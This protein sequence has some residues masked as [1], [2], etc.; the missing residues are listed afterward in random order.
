MVVVETTVVQVQLKQFR[1]EQPT[2]CK[3]RV[4]VKIEVHFCKHFFYLK[5]IQKVKKELSFI[6]YFRFVPPQVRV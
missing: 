6:F 2:L 5:Y 1:T 3:D 4:L